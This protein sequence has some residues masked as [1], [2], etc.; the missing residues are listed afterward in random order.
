M[1]ALSAGHSHLGVF[2]TS[3][4]LGKFYDF[5]RAV[6]LSSLHSQAMIKLVSGKAHSELGNVIVECDIE[7][8]GR[9]LRVEE[10]Q[11]LLSAYNTPALC[12]LSH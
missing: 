7:K 2:Y 6:W 4:F 9:Y 10:T 5:S 1:P 11:C 3:F 12:I 8:K